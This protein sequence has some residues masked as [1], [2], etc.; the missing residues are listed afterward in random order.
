MASTSTSTTAPSTA[1]SSGCARSSRRSTV[2]SRRSKRFTGWAIATATG[3][4]AESAAGSGGAE[5][6]GR[7]AG[8]ISARH[9]LSPLTRRILAVNVLALA[10][11]GLGFLYLGEYRNSLIETELDALKTQGE[12]SAAALSE[13]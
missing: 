1:T 13:G 6:A 8:S 2:N 12:I 3:D 7:V 10:L 9:R 11:L 4:R 5:R